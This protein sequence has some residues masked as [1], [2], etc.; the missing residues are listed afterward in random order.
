VIS[1][2]TGRQ[3]VPQIVADGTGGA[4]MAW[5]DVRNGNLDIYAQRVN[6]SGE[7][8]WTTDG[9]AIVAASGNQLDL[10]IASDG[11]GGAIVTWTDYRIG[12]ADIYAQRVNGQGATLWAGDGVAVSTSPNDQRYPQLVSD[13]VGGVIVTWEDIRAGLGNTDVYAQR[14]NADGLG[15][16]TTDGV[17]LS[18]APRSQTAPVIATDH[19]GGAIIAWTDGRAANPT[20]ADIYAQRVNA[21]GQVLWAADGAAIAIGGTEPRIRPNPRVISGDANGAIVV[22]REASPS[23]IDIC[24]QQVA[25]D[26]KRFTRKS[27]ATS[28]SRNFDAASDG[29]GGVI[30]AWDNTD[31]SG[32]GIYAQRIDN[33]GQ[34]RWLPLG[35]EIAGAVGRQGFP[36]VMG[37]GSGGIIIAWSDSRSGTVFGDIY[38]QRL[39][40]QGQA[41]WT[42]NGVGLV[43]ATGGPGGFGDEQIASDGAGGAI[44]VWTDGRDIASFTTDIY[45]Q[46]IRASGRQ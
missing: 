43:T 15:L 16:W 9:V 7:V 1:H 40:A 30:V 36:R 21:D 41:L 22:W 19:A 2:A 23:C 10:Q 27:V 39:D 13:G 11:A 24:V 33:L 42:V 18:A 20:I 14:L 31:F 37:D 6:A 45:A 38:A 4:I 28:G 17:V 46:G 5:L 35:V 12:N 3:T 8:Q 25:A 32:S 29:A 44:F 34:T 26:G